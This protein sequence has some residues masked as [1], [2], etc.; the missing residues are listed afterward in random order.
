MTHLYFIRHGEA[1]SNVNPVIGG[2][3]GC[4]GLTDR[5]HAQVAALAERLAGGEIAADVLIAS[6]LP[7]AR[8]TAE[9]VAAALGLPIVWDDE[10]HEL[11]PGEADGMTY[12]DARAQF[13]GFPRFLSDF[14]TPL[15]PGGES[16]GSFQM[17]VG[18][19]I[20][21]ITAEHAGKTVAVVCHGGVIECSFFHF[22]QLGP[23]ARGRTSFH[24][25]NTAITHWR[26]NQ[27]P[28]GRSEWHM[29]AHND[30]WHLRELDG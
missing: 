21:R 11:R 12:D 28:A 17:R 6:T 22:L 16:W 27:T 7:R 9:P 2:M 19:A 15:A 4:L 5:G 30:C 1:H 23:Q 29:A 3:R 13:P 10:V 26:F 8:Q 24:V 14:Y 20:E 25:R 18:A